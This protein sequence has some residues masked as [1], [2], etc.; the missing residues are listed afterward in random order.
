MELSDRP[1][2]RQWAHSQ[3]NFRCDEASTHIQ[4]SQCRWGTDFASRVV[5][6]EVQVLRGLFI[7]TKDNGTVRVAAVADLHYGRASAGSLQWLSAASEQ[8]DILLI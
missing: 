2:W 6:A 5:A 4:Q 7:M 1:P 8:A 3:S